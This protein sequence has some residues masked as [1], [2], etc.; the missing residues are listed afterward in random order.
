MPRSSVEAKSLKGVRSFIKEGIRNSAEGI[1]FD[2][3]RSSAEVELRNSMEEAEFAEASTFADGP[4]N[5]Q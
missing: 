5:D 4:S 3:A 1:N 2:V